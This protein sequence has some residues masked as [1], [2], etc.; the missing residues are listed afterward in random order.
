M[1]KKKLIIF[2]LDGTLYEF[3]GGSY[4]GSPLSKQVRLNATKFLQN[5]LNLSE[6]EV[7]KHIDYIFDEQ[8]NASLIIEKD[9]G[10]NRYD[11]FKAVWDIP[12]AGMITFNPELK[13]ILQ[14]L[15]INNK[16]ALVS[17]APAVWVN[18]VLEELGVKQFFGENIFTGE[19]ANRKHFGNSFKPILEKLQFT[20]Q[21]CVSV[22]DQEATDIIPAKELGMKTVFVSKLGKGSE[23][24]DYNI[25]NIKEIINIL[26]GN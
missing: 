2:D 22:G 23:M 13:Q 5:K 9:F 6:P 15:S 24:A 19:G 14:T 11:Y 4:N 10:I 25:V 1:N 3:E 26:G 21:N 12:A 7:K 18:N 8:D 20:P 17:D 16:L